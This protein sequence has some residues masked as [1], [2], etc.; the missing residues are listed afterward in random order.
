MDE[1][2]V[3]QKNKDKEILSFDEMKKMLDKYVEEYKCIPTATT[4]YDDIKLGQWF[5]SQKGRSDSNG[6]F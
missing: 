4:K 3:N 1:Y 2:L 6:D 5:H